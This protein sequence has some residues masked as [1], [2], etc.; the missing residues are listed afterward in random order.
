MHIQGMLHRQYAGVRTLH[1][2]EILAAAGEK[3]A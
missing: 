3:S 1:V 2:A